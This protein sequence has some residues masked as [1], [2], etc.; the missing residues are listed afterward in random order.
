MLSFSGKG[1]IDEHTGKLIVGITALFLATFT[2]Y[3]A[4]DV[5]QSISDSYHESGWSRDIFVGSLFAISAFLLS[6]NGHSRP[7]MVAS[8]IAAFAAIGVAIFPCVCE[9]HEEIIPYVHAGSAAVVFLILAFF[10]YTFYIRAK[11]KGTSRAKFRAYV[12]AA[13]G[14]AIVAS[15]VVIALDALLDGAIRATIPRLVFYGENV[16][17]VA[18]GI[19]WL[20]ASRILPGFTTKDD[21]LPLFK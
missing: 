11:D 7:Q 21:R 10:C 2:N 16:G 12:Y 6:F 15:V 17:L 18:F 19:A 5:L 13:C 14:I 1:E 20:S 8:K 9:V 4:E 3:F